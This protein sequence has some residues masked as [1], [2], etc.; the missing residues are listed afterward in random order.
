MK[1]NEIEIYNDFQKLR[2]MDM[3]YRQLTYRLKELQEKFPPDTL[4]TEQQL[5][6]IKLYIALRFDFE[7]FIEELDPYYKKYG[8]KS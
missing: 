1:L 4:T 7:R 5:W 2:G 6:F 3:S 8:G